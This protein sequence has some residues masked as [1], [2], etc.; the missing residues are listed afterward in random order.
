MPPDAELP[1][2]L[3]ADELC[4]TPAAA[5]ARLI[6]TRQVSPVAVVEAVLKRAEHVEPAL[7]IFALPMAEAARAAARS[8]EAAVMRGDSFGPLHG[9]PITIKDNVPIGGL[10]LANG[11]AALADFVPPADAAVVRRIRAAGAI[12]I[13]K[14]NL[15]EFAHKV[16]TDSPAYGVTR[17]PWNLAYTPGGSSGGASAALAAGVAPLAV[18]TDGGG[19]IRFPAACTGVVGLKPTLGL[20]PSERVPDGFANYSF[21][22]PMARSTGDAALLLSVMAGRDDGDPFSIAADAVA[23]P[24]PRAVENAARG[25]R[26]GW[27]EHFGRYRT[28][29]AV[30]T[31]TGAAVSALADRGAIIEPLHDPCFDDVFERYIV[32][33]TSAHATRYG[34][35]VE[36]WGDRMSISIKASIANGQRYSAVDWMRAHDWRTGLFRAV[37]RLFERYDVIA[38]PTMT[39]PPKPL[40][41]E[42]SIAT[43][44]YAEWAAP[45][46]PF[47]LTGHP[48]ISLPGGLTTEGL[49]VGLQ[50][51][52]PWFGERRLL[53]V[54]ELL[55]TVIGWPAWRAGSNEISSIRS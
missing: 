13:G 18:G 32:I 41:A 39:A 31:L 45:L 10:P 19:S 21:I 12:I 28:E 47:N 15:P 4:F 11:S 49:P 51:V 36:K 42:G 53:D 6:A 52:G 24:A 54:A 22:G 16:V 48:A 33:A 2:A 14:T 7:N 50:L 43:E 30:A 37:Q 9:V 20:V 46:Y 44:A 38:T 26:V 17:S 23:M 40:D 1:N 3:T 34:P 55:E 29:E 27:I 5:L 25:L 8:A 35:L